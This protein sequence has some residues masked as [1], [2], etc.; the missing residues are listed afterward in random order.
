MKN[1]SLHITHAGIDN[2]DKSWL[3]KAARNNLD[4]RRWNV[5]KSVRPGD[6]LVIY[7]GGYGFFAT[8]AITSFAKPRTDWRNRYTASLSQIILID[9]PISLASIQKHIPSLSWANHPR[10]ITTPDADTAKLIRKLIDHRRKTGIPD[11]DIE[12]VSKA[13]IDELRKLAIIS[14][15]QSIPSKQRTALHRPGSLAIKRYVLLRSKGICE[16]C[17]KVAPFNKADGTPYLEPHHTKRRADGGPDHP[18]HVIALCP[19]CHRRAH[20]AN[21]SKEFNK[22]LL[23]TLIKI[24][25]N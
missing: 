11:T 1:K 4:S 24:E 9:P 3:K 2:G 14:S 16:G 6:D 8:A 15:K 22:R 17:K 20:Y 21:D 7:V 25:L 10:S 23:K 12:T 5:P 18:A 13:N 19:N